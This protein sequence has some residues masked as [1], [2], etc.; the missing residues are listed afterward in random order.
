MYPIEAVWIIF[1]VLARLSHDQRRRALDVA[2]IGQR[3]APAPD[4]KQGNYW[5]SRNEFGFHWMSSLRMLPR[6][7]F[8]YDQSGMPSGARTNWASSRTGSKPPVAAL[9]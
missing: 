8:I 3:D 2:G 6:V 7:G 4:K 5:H 9:I 1:A